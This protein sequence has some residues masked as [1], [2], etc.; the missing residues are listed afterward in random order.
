MLPN[1]IEWLLTAS[2]KYSVY[3]AF[4]RGIN[5]CFD[6]R[7]LIDIRHHIDGSGRSAFQN[8]NLFPTHI[9]L[10]AFSAFMRECELWYAQDIWLARRSIGAMIYTSDC[11]SKP[12]VVF[13]LQK[14]IGC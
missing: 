8:N 5:G 7:R 3:A 10:R 9:F 13:A 6:L 4:I 12:A 2:R 11:K 1:R 14:T